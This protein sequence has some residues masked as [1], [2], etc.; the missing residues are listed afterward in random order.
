[1]TTFYAKQ[2]MRVELFADAEFTGRMI[3][4]VAF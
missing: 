2:F 3:R 1:M 4:D